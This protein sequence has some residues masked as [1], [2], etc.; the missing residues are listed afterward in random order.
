MQMVAKE[1]HIVKEW[2]VTIIGVAQDYLVCFL[3]IQLSIW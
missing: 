2:N 1:K 3:K